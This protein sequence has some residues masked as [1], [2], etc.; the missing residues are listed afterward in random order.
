MVS[1]IEELA[2]FRRM[3]GQER[4]SAIRVMLVVMA[5]KASLI[6]LCGAIY[7]V[8]VH[9][10]S[11]VCSRVIL[12]PIIAIGLFALAISSMGCYG[13]VRRDE[14]CKRDYLAG[15]AVVILAVLGFVI[16]GFVATGGIDVGVVKARE[17]N[18]GDYSGWLRGRV[19]DPRYW[20]TISA[21]LRDK[22]AC[23]GMSQLV[24]DPNT[25]TYV[26]EHSWAKEHDMGDGPMPVESGC[27][28]PPSSCAFT[29][30]NGTTWIP[31]PGAP[32]VATND[33]CSRWSND[34][35][36]LC[37][38]CDSCKAGFL[39]DTKKGW[40][41]VAVFLV[42]VLILLI[43]TF[44]NQVRAMSDNDPRYPLLE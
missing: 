2:K 4:S 18:L 30:V 5:F 6:M 28:K 38:Q 37:L 41:V 11:A 17:Y 23:D 24:L 21:C 32:A 8:L 7:L 33:D 43:I 12:W 10:I 31:T 36:T 22:H 3:N 26:P 25:G 19:A 16:F 9:N 29:Y 27:C 13:M 34:Q 42:V 1:A 40:S 44:P 15:L 14:A 20:A 35:Q 39:D